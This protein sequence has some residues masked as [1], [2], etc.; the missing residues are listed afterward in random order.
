MLNEE[1]KHIIQNAIKNDADCGSSLEDTFSLEEMLFYVRHL[2]MSGG[3]VGKETVQKVVKLARRH[4]PWYIL[5]IGD[6]GIPY[7]ENGKGYVF[8]DW[9]TGVQAKKIF[10]SIGYE[11]GLAKV[12]A[13]DELPF[14]MFASYGVQT[15]SINKGASGIALKTDLLAKT[16]SAENVMLNNALLNFAIAAK[17]GS[18]LVTELDRT[19]SGLILKSELYFVPEGEWWS[20]MQ[21][22][23]EFSEGGSAIGGYLFSDRKE[24]ALMYLDQISALR[25]APVRKIFGADPLIGKYVLNPGSISLLISQSTVDAVVKKQI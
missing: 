12:D 25:K 19:V 11:L 13:Y 5:T 1:K 16:N 21:E 15:T 20:P 9:G 17:T 7:V 22:I 23:I 14:D 2:Q 4:S 24:A 6:E 8:T 3:R 18:H 10:S